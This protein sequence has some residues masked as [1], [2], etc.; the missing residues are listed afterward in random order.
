MRERVRREGWNR[1]KEREGGGGGGKKEK[2]LG[3]G[4]RWER[5]MLKER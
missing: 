2:E 5:D 4:G 1:E 3:G